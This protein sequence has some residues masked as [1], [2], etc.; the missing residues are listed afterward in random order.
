[1]P[2]KVIDWE[3]G[4]AKIIDQTKLPAEFKYLYLNDIKDM[5]KAI[6]TMQIR[7]APALGVAAAFGVVL[8]IKNLKTNKFSVLKKKVNDSINYLMT[9]RPTAVNLFWALERMKEKCLMSSHLNVEKIKKLLL[10]EAIEIL[11]EDRRVCKKIGDH[12]QAL[13]KNK[14]IILT[15]CNAGG[16]ATSEFGTA[17]SCIYRAKAK[18]KKVKVYV[19]ETRPL[20]QGS[21][22]TAWE[23]MKNNIETTVICDDMAAS[24]MKKGLIDKIIV[25]A[26]RIARN[27]DT[28]N[29]IGTYNLAVLAKFHKVPFYIAAPISTFDFNIKSGKQIPIEQRSREEIIRGFGK[30]TAPENVKVYNPAFDVTP[31]GLITAIITEI[32][33][34][35][36]PFTKSIQKL[37]K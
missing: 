26:D 6:R 14:D 15:H 11:E 25:G 8:G 7:G 27:G 34:L 16:L 5:H 12:G 37:R 22:L 2:L 1:M 20:L 35:Q 29:K 18:G 33:I 36:K 13:I 31:H 9:S 4:K 21:R 28:A 3:K 10:K 32:G 24:V 23:L 19:D 30:L 17:L